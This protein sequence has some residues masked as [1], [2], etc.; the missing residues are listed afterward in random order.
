[1]KFYV[2]RDTTQGIG[3]TILNFKVRN[4]TWEPYEGLDTTELEVYDT[5]GV[6][7]GDSPL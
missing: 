5:E 7:T 6:E 2:L 3:D 1:M 4:E